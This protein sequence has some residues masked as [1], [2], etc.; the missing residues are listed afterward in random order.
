M[1]LTATDRNRDAILIC[2]V[3]F[4]VLDVGNV[5]EALKAR[6]DFKILEKKEGRGTSILWLDNPVRP[7]VMPS[8][9]RPGRKSTWD[10][11]SQQPGSDRTHL[12]SDDG[13][14]LLGIITLNPERLI[15]ECVTKTQAAIGQEMLLKVAGTNLRYRITTYETPIRPNPPSPPDHLSPHLPPEFFKSYFE[16]RWV[17]EKIPALSGLTP[18]QCARSKRK[19]ERDRLAALLATLKKS[20]IGLYDFNRLIDILGFKGHPLL[21]EEHITRQRLKEKIITVI[22]NNLRFTMAVK[23]VGWD[24][25]TTLTQRLAEVNIMLQGLVYFLEQGKRT[26]TE[27][28]ALTRTLGQIEEMAQILQTETLSGNLHRKTVEELIGDPNW[29][30]RQVI[31]TEV[32]DTVTREIEKV[33]REKI[34]QKPISP[35]TSFT[36]ALN[37]IPALWVAA[38]QENLDLPRETTKRKNVKIIVENLSHPKILNKIVDKLTRL[39]IP[40]VK[41][42]KTIYI[43]GGIY[44]YDK[45]IHLV[46]SETPICLQRTKGEEDNLPNPPHPPFPKGGYPLSP[47]SEKWRHP[48]PSLLGKDGVPVIPPL[49]KGPPYIPPLEKGPPYI[50]PLEK[51]PPYIP[52]LEK[53]PPYIPPLEKGDTGGF[54]GEETD[55]YFWDK[56]K[57]SSPLGLLRS[58]GLL[59]VGQSKKEGTYYKIAVIPA[60]IR[61]NLSFL[62]GILL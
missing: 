36:T 21:R 31:T 38:I 4:D 7:D 34:E 43:H 9:D 61:Q 56:R 24:T 57:P 42:L 37:N 25:S 27:L 60:E 52:P 35:H 10:M 16:V 53:G 48:L 44:P 14:P 11:T 51:G 39:S 49:K 6:P 33:W 2:K 58:H 5:L 40:A 23:K 20:S 47:P 28:T 54:L 29:D 3:I 55:G 45:L 12:I 19:K 26:K 1:P 59:F 32:V 46:S 15:L 18:L 22:D 50:P 17:H 62:E 41:A 13:Q 8:A 30:H